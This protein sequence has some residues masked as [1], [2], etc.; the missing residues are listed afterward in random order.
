MFMETISERAYLAPAELFA[1]R[2][3]GPTGSLFYQRFVTMADA[4]KFAVE[5][6]PAGSSNTSIETDLGR[7]DG[8]DIAFL[9][10]ADQFPLKRRSRYAL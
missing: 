5:E 8:A 7:I 4:I 3:R 6:M 1:V 2:R 10:E 9:Y